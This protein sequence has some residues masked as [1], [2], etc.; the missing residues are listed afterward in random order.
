MATTMSTK[1]GAVSHAEPVIN[2]IG[3][4][5]LR[6]A[7]RRGWDD[8][9]AIPTQLFFLCI[10]YAVI[11][12]IAA[13]AAATGRMMPLL[14]PLVSGFALVGPL[15]ALG[16]YELSRRREKGLAVAWYDVFGVLKSPAIVSIGFLAVGLVAIFVAWLAVAQGIYDSTMGN[17]RPSSIGE[18]L[19]TVFG[20]REG[21]RLI[22]IGNAV[23]FLFS[24][25]VLT[26]TVVS[27]PM[28]LDRHVDPGVAVR[29]SIRAVMANPVPMGIW[30]IIVGSLV[31]LGSIP[32]FIGLAV[33]LP[34]LGHATWHLYRRVVAD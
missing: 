25:V 24:A 11:G 21:W 2:R 31:V 22:I 4:A 9:L 12:L 7:L 28:L 1:T 18:F 32:L 5:D 20:T 26:L 8:F 17:Y 13:R 29:T 16:L 6:E 14:W 3:T 30:G 34:V 15:A 10:L 23:G 19:G 33:V 27:F